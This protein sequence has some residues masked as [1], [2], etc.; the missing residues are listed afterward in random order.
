MMN[1]A[2]CWQKSG[3]LV[4]AL[5]AAGTVEVVVVASAWA[6]PCTCCCLSRR[7]QKPRH[8]GIAKC[9]AADVFSFFKIGLV[10]F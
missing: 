8:C 9:A 5:G 1:N 10:A 2:L 3:R 6:V 7:E 4:I